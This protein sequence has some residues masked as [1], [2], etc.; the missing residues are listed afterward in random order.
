MPGILE[1]PIGAAEDVFLCRL[2]VESV[3][4][5]REVSQGCERTGRRIGRFFQPPD[6]TPAGS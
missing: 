6:W 1:F 5:G 2:L 3:C 4:S